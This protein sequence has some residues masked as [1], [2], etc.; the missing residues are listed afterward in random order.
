MSC[1]TFRGMR[2]RS[3]LPAVPL[4]LL[5]VGRF[6]P[7]P[8]A[9]GFNH[10]AW[11]PTPLLAG[12][13][14]LAAV[15]VVPGARRGLANWLAGPGHDFLFR[16]RRGPWVLALG[17]GAL[18]VLFRERSYFMGDGY[19]VGEL[20]D[21]GLPFRAF[22]SLD[23]LLHYQIHGWFKGLNRPVD[24]FLIYRVGSVL[25]GIFALLLWPRL[26]ARLSW[27]PWRKTALLGV[28]LFT[29]PLALFF[30]YVESYSFLY[31]FM[32]AFLLTGLLALDGRSRLWVPAVWFGLGLSFHLTAVFSAPALLVLALKS[33]AGPASRRWLALALPPALLFLLAVLLHLAEGYNATWFRREFIEAK[34]T[35]N[36]WVSFGGEH[37]LLSA[38]HWKD[39]LNLALMTAPVAL[40]VVVGQVQEIRRRWREPSFLFLLAQIAS[41]AFFSVALDRK[42]GGA[43]D[44]DLLA[45]HTAGL[46]LL[47]GLLL[48]AIAPRAKTPGS[49][50]HP[51]AAFA[52][53]AALLTTAPWVLLLHLEERS[54]RR[55][56]AVASD[57]PDFQRAYAYEEV[58]KYY[59]KAAGALQAQEAEA[60]SPDGSEGTEEGGAS[61]G[62]EARRKMDLARQM[63]E[64]A[65]EANPSHARLRV[66]LGSICF[67]Q[68]DDARAEEQYRE[69]LRLDPKSFMAIEM[70]GRVALRRGEYAAAA[71][72]FRD[73]VALRPN[74]AT[75]WELYGYASARS[76]RFPEALHGLSR[77]M[78]LNPALNY[79]HEV[80]VSLMR[81]D[82]PAEAIEAFREACRRPDV[83]VESR[84]GLAVAL[85][86]KIEADRAQGNP[87][88]PALLA[89]AEE[90]LREVLALQPESNQARQLWQSLEHLRP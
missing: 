52:V 20:I 3:W 59:R 9:W 69:A 47:A 49:A 66:L 60:G 30:G 12:W 22:D 63:Y 38:Y 35:R 23:Y 90:Q 44:W 83:P 78:A 62:A 21:R 32:T 7:G 76:G 28:L 81:L 42:L 88:P 37:G 29:G 5:V 39:L 54:I 65:V 77:A 36:L 57:F 15:I 64:R 33:K 31:V 71:D 16:T 86:A 80:G 72:R 45:A 26:I 82:R 14:I 11:L 17:G 18:F 6:L 53:G 48:P 46:A 87:A 2:I 75:A 25:A 61:R 74:E 73:L 4:L 41:V 85:A 34:N 13:I 24:S 27:E 56:V 8:A 55:F 89:E 67:S 51:V 40:A 70:L 10:F 79:H 68:D 58:G 43:R 50:P 19:L 84:L 1:A